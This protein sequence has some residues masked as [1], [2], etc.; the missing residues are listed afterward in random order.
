MSSLLS[1]GFYLRRDYTWNRK[2]LQNPTAQDGLSTPVVD[3]LVGPGTLGGLGGIFSMG[4]TTTL[5]TSVAFSR[6]GSN[7]ADNIFTSAISFNALAGDDL[8]FGTTQ[9]QQL[10]G[11]DGN[12]VINGGGGADVINGG[13]GVNQIAFGIIGTGVRGGTINPYGVGVTVNLLAGTYSYKTT[14][15]ARGVCVFAGASGK[16]LNVTQV[17]GSTGSDTITGENSG[18]VLWGNESSDIIVGGSGGDVIFGDGNYAASTD[19]ND[20]IRAGVGRDIIY[21]GLGADTIDGS[22]GNNFIHGDYHAVP[23]GTLVDGRD[24]ITA[25]HGDNTV[26]GG[27][28]DDRI[29]L[30]HGRNRIY[31][32]YYGLNLGDGADVIVAGNG[33]NTVFGGGGADTVTTGSGVDLIYADNLYLLDTAGNP[34]RN[35]SPDTANPTLAGNDTVWSGAGNDTVLGG[36]GDDVISGGAGSDLLVGNEGND[37]IYS[38]SS[39]AYSLVVP[40]SVGDRIYLSGGAPGFPA[41]TGFDGSPDYSPGARYSLASPDPL[42]GTNVAWVGYDFDPAT[43]AAKQSSGPLGAV[44]LADFHPAS[45]TLHVASGAVAIIGGVSSV[46]DWSG[47]DTLDLS[48]AAAD[49]QGLIVVSTGAGDD[50]VRPGYGDYRIYGNDGLNRVELQD[51]TRAD[52]YI[53]TFASRAMVTGF[54]DDDRI[55]VNRALVDAF[56]PYRQGALSTTTSD[57]TSATVADGQALNAGLVGALTFSA[58]YNNYLGRASTLPISGSQV[59]YMPTLPE[60]GYDPQPYPSVSPPGTNSGIS[61]PTPAAYATWKSNGA[62]P[63]EVYRYAAGFGEVSDYIAGSALLFVGYY[64]LAPIPIVGPIISIASIVLGALHIND[65]VNEVRPHLNATYSTSANLTSSYASVWRADGDVTYGDNTAWDNAP[66]LGLYQPSY[67]GAAPALEVTA[68]DLSSSV[69]NTYGIHSIVAVNTKGTDGDKTYVYLVNSPDNLVQNSEAKLL[70]QVDYRL[71]ADQVVVYDGAT[72]PYNQPGAVTPVLPPA[73]VSVI[74]DGGDAAGNDIPGGYVTTS[75]DP[76][77]NVSFG[78]PLS[79][80]DTV[81]LYRGDTLIQTLVRGSGGTG[82]FDPSLLVASFSSIPGFTSATSSSYTVVATSVQGFTSEWSGRFVYDANSPALAPSLAYLHSTDALDPDEEPV[83]YSAGLRPTGSFLKVS[84]NKEGS[85]GLSTDTSRVNTGLTGAGSTFEGVLKDFADY[86]QPSTAVSTRIFATDALGLRQEIGALGSVDNPT[87]MI[88]PSGGGTVT[89]GGTDVAVYATGLYNT[90]YAGTAGFVMVDDARAA[91]A[92]VSIGAGLTIG[93]IDSVKIN[94]VRHVIESYD[95]TTGLATVSS[96]APGALGD[97][98]LDDATVTLT[99]VSVSD[100]GVVS[101]SNTLKADQDVDFT[102]GVSGASTVYG[103]AAG[104]IIYGGGGADVLYASQSSSAAGI[105]LVAGGPGQVLRSYGNADYLFDSEYGGTTLIGGGGADTID[106]THG[107]NT[108]RFLDIADA[109]PNAHPLVKGFTAGEGTVFDLVPALTKAIDD[110]ATAIDEY[111]QTPLNF[112][113]EI[114]SATDLASAAGSLTVGD[115]GYVQ[116]DE[117][118]TGKSTYIVVN[119]TSA[120]GAEMVI[121]LAGEHALSASDFIYQASIASASYET[122]TNTLV[123][124]GTGFNTAASVDV[125]KLT[126]DVDGDGSVTPDLNL[127]AAYV[128]SARVDSSTRITVTLTS[129]TLEGLAGFGGATADTLDVAAGFLGG[130]PASFDDVA[131]SITATASAGSGILYGDSLDDALVGTSGADVLVGGGGADS[132][133][134]GPGTDVITLGDGSDTVIFDSL[135]G[136]DIVT[137]Y[138][139]ADDS[140]QLSKA[141]FAALGAVGALLSAEFYSAA[142]AVAGADASDRMVYDSASGRLYYDADGSGAIGAVLIGTFIGSPTLTHSE[143]AII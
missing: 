33:G 5:N 47:A 30:G 72:D 49:N 114:T 129:G 120:A 4:M 84:S 48:T 137:D 39:G 85:A 13:A 67:D 45:D 35:T 113:G 78:G 8:V 56:G 32:D 69:A 108:V 123:L 106:V 60:H 133:T 1:Y 136:S 7:R 25:A 138:S 79:S 53:D 76:I 34:Y 70:A 93:A 36:G 23:T 96:T 22:A 20:T 105:S 127:S 28:A 86:A 99:Q 91:T 73:V 77:L 119:A 52:V 98:S 66:F 104:Q 58:T 12:D 143:F 111:A 44:V 134:G 102:G 82:T 128:T 54:S 118:A 2:I 16:V 80:T 3:F 38:G 71:T 10:L 14:Y 18:D 125:T 130:A 64:V 83:E 9:A 62:Y 63:N 41:S 101:E 11:G 87:V 112:V 135:I 132:L 19:G 57:A 110:T 131:T 140:V 88:G 141:T 37:A 31:G 50:T 124:T 74:L 6:A 68:A 103:E 142:G 139:V 92:E 117:T 29:T 40:Y 122:T 90:I 46:M 27:G 55:L 21:G 126:W 26:Y 42:S 81:Q 100:T 95:A 75:P 43:S 17:W 61:T 97:V 15:D 115:F 89:A 65:A 51:N 24:V 59:P 116:L 121:R 94:G 107:N 109:T